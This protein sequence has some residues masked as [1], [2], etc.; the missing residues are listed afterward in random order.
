MGI[1]AQPFRREYKLHKTMALA[2]GASCM[3]SLVLSTLTFSGMQMAKPILTSSQPL[4]I[5]GG[6]L[7]SVLFVFLLTCLGNLERL[8]F[9]QGF[10]SKWPEAVICLAISVF[11]TA[12]I[13][14]VSATTCVLFS[15]LML[16]SMCGIAS[17]AY[18]A[19]SQQASEP[20]RQEKS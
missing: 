19:K 6:F 14:R 17:Q 3:V 1:P 9:G 20:P 18:D 8:L 15:A 12:S 10:Q 4:T 16:Y 11:A 5:L 13:H 2:V 7:G